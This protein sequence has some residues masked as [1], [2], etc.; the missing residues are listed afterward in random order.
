M[1]WE[2]KNKL[3][4]I[5]G[6]PAENI[7]LG[8]GSDEAIDLLFRIF[9]TPG[10]DNVIIFHPT[11]GMYEVCAETN[12]VLVKKVPLLDNFQLNLEAIEENIDADTK[13][14]FICS[15]NNPTGNSINRTDIE[16]LLNNFDG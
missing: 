12:D 16:V 10:K 11:Y 3:S 13:L 14:I 1:Q 4:G 7:F 15:P 8:N 6:V 2:L 9:C 5:K